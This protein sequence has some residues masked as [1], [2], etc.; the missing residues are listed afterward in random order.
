MATDPKAKPPVEPDTYTFGCGCGL[1]IELD[2]PTPAELA[3]AQRA[4]DTHECPVLSAPC[5]H[6]ASRRHP[7][8][9]SARAK[10][11]PPRFTRCECGEIFEV[12]PA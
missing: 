6:P 9:E 12:R 5:T 4:F 3:K 10:L 11:G 8:Y 7:Y 1:W 2:H